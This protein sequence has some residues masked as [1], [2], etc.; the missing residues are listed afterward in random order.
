[1][2][3]ESLAERGSILYFTVMDLTKLSCMYQHSVEWFKALFLSTLESTDPNLVNIE[4]RLAF[5]KR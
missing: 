1:M 5:M 2:I 3:Y 4:R